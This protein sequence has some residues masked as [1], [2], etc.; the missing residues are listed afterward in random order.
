[1]GPSVGDRVL[2]GSIRSDIESVSIGVDIFYECIVHNVSSD[3]LW[4]TAP[5]SFVDMKCTIQSIEG[6]A[7]LESYVCER[8][9]ATLESANNFVN[10]MVVYLQ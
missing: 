10:D 5:I 6:L 4:K 9:D 3:I 8:D 7:V 1:M 2:V